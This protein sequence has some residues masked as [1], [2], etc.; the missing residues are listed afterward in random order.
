MPTIAFAIA[1]LSSGVL[2]GWLQQQGSFIDKSF[3]S[4]IAG[5]VLAAFGGFV[6]VF[7]SKVIRHLGDDWPAFIAISGLVAVLWFVFGS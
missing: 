7:W 3:A 5:A 4:L 1:G 2:I 6:G